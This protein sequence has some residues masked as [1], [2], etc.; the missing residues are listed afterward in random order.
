MTADVHAAAAGTTPEE[1]SHLELKH[2]YLDELHR[3]LASEKPR[4]RP[5]GIR[6]IIDYTETHP[7]AVHRPDGHRAW[8]WSDLHL[9]HAN[10]IKHC[11]RPFADAREM[12]RALMTAWTSA[13]GPDDTVLNGGDV[14]LAG[15]LGERGRARL[16][17]APGRKLLVVGN[18]D[19]GGR[20]GLLEPA[21]HE[22][23]TGILAVDTDP[24]LVLTHVPM[25]VVPPGWV[26]LHGHV[27]NNE[28]LRATPHI[29]VCVEHTDYRPLPLESLVTLAKRLLAGEVPDGATT[30]DR[31]R[32][33]AT[34]PGARAAAEASRGGSTE[35]ASG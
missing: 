7:V 22:A 29:N 26:N 1:R 33:A 5:R 11:N 34:P 30:G 28:P 2:L 25:G 20:T 8:V 15:S 13:V 27:H 4:A 9:R 19:F 32:S 24:P 14:A 3:N 16:R 17:G 12:D 23:A 21:G 18:H 31:I 35:R 10:I 6:W